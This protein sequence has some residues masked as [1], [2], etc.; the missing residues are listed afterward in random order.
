MGIQYTKNEVIILKS[1]NKYYLN[2]AY[3]FFQIY[4]VLEN[5]NYSYIF[6]LLY[7]DKLSIKEIASLANLSRKTIFNIRK[8]FNTL[9]TYI[10]IN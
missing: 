8:K 5:Q 7:F 4:D 1:G 6:K 10:I 9:L 3:I 2:L